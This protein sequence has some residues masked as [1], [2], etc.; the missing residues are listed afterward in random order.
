MKPWGSEIRPLR[1]WSILL[2]ETSGPSCVEG[3]AMTV[4]NPVHQ[5]RQVTVNWDEKRGQGIPGAN[6]HFA[7]RMKFGTAVVALVVSA[8]A[9]VLLTL[10]PTPL[11]KTANRY[12]KIADRSYSTS[13]YLLGVVSGPANPTQLRTAIENYPSK[14]TIVV[15]TW[16][17]T[18]TREDESFLLKSW[19]RDVVANV[20]GLVAS[21][22]AQIGAL[23]DFGTDTSA[24]R[25][26]V[27]AKQQ[28]FADTSAHFTNRIR[29]T[30]HI[31]NS[32]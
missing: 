8:V 17:L 12:L 11:T 24:Q 19:P 13:S 6:P 30:L 23:A 31:P 32:D 15:A 25:R 2:L 28:T 1:S 7:G 16:V 9:L 29:S 27:L 10:G 4:E 18:L 20:N 26:A 14:S 3:I 22:Q 5:V 21:N